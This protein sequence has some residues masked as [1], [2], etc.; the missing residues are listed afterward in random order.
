MNL[1]EKQ[2][3]LRE[4]LID[5]MIGFAHKVLNKDGMKELAILMGCKEPTMVCFGEI[6]L[7]ESE[8]AEAIDSILDVGNELFED[9]ERETFK[10]ILKEQG[11]EFKICPTCQNLIINGHTLPDGEDVY[12]TFECLDKQVPTEEFHKRY[13]EVEDSG[14]PWPVFRTKEKLVWDD[15]KNS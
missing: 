2:L 3:K 11:I 14:S 8:V 1:E 12:C 4:V 10:K 5:E 15:E 13:E 7:N 6:K 9:S